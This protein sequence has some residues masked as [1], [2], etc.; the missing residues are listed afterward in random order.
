VV[1]DIGV[2]ASTDIVAIDQAAYDMIVRAPGLPGGRGEGMAPG[3]DKFAAITG[4]DGTVAMRYA[5]E[6]GLGSRSY[7]LRTME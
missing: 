5:E 4:V 7:E 3:D 1:A 2:L 6:H